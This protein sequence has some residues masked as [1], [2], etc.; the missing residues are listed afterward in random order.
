[1]SLVVA[2]ATT[3]GPRI[4]SDTHFLAPRGRSSTFK[5][6]VLKAIVLR[7]DVCI[8]FA[9][10]IAL[11]LAGARR[12]AAVLGAGASL[13]SLPQ[14]LGE[15]AT[16]GPRMVEFI[17]ASCRPGQQLWRITTAGVEEHLSTAWIGDEAAFEAFQRARY[18]ATRSASLEDADQRRTEGQ[19]AGIVLGRAMEAVIDD[20]QVASVYGFCVTV[21]CTDEG[22]RYMDAAK[23]FLGRPVSIPSDEETVIP[24]LQPV[25]DG[26]YHF[27]IVPPKNPGVPVLGIS[28]ANARL[29]FLLLPL[30]FDEPEVITDVPARE[31]VSRIR[32]DYGIEMNEP[33]IR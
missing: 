11:G 5:D 6:I 12:A 3:N 9:G 2:Q 20:A 7:E 32:A 14:V 23:A 28:F 22:F 29:A 13:D 1:M 31:F 16:R 19:R 24:F 8:C 27:A 33:M 10:E 30:E 15:F 18:E 4:A 17:V 21:A 25:Q 26:A